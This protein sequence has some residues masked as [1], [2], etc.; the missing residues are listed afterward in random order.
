MKKKK[1]KQ[2][3]SNFSPLIKSEADFRYIESL[4]HHSY[5]I[6]LM[7]D[8]VMVNNSLFFSKET[9]NKHYIS[10]M[11][12]LWGEYEQAKNTSKLKGAGEAILSLKVTQLRVH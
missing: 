4:E 9:A 2:P 11:Q 12:Q 7:G 3:E 1:A 6:S 8:A 10:L 5:Y